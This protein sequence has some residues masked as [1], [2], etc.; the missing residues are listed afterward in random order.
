MPHVTLQF[1]FSSNWNSHF[2][3]LFEKT[4][5]DYSTISRKN[6]IT[7]EWSKGLLDNGGIEILGK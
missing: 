6:W 7:L 2:I 1:L 5:R 3:S 4:L